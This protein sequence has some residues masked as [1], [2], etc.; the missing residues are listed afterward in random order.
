MPKRTRI[1]PETVRTVY[2][3][4]QCGRETA[5][6]MGI[7]ESTVY[8]IL[9][10]LRGIC[11]RCSNP[12]NPGNSYCPDCQKY[13]RER[14]KEKRRERRR[15]GLCEMCDNP[16]QPP[17]IKFCA[18]HRIRQ[19]DYGERVQR[20]RKRG[21][22]NPGIRTQT[23]RERGL[24]NKYGLGGVEVWNRHNGCCSMCGVSYTEKA[25]HIHHIDANDRNHES[26][27][28]IPL[29]FR[30]HKLVHLVIEHPDLPAVLGWLRKTYPSLPW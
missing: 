14:I 15:Q 27:N 17:S 3:R 16:I 21:A 19:F 28:L 29:C 11:K 20:R 23:D 6:E 24:R 18:E 1:D 22:P 5:R 13:L 12:V 10:K 7:H 4:T 25:I 30:C 9:K 8:Q 26:S 2:A